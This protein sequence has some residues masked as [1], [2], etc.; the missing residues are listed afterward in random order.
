MQHLA[1]RAL[2]G[3]GGGVTG[4]VWFFEY[5]IFQRFGEVG[6]G[7]GSII[8]KHHVLSIFCCILA[9]ISLAGL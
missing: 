9:S 5:R 7:L 2:G 8:P 6:I 4:V 3:C 1:G